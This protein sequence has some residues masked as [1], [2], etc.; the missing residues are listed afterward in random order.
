MALT[1]SSV[2]H[3]GFEKSTPSVILMRLFVS[4]WTYYDNNDNNDSNNDWHLY[5]TF[6]PEGSQSALQTDLQTT[7][8]PY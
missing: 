8:R 7:A 3:C 5:S 6:H 1:R 2:F 4:L